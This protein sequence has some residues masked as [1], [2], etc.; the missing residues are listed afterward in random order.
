MVDVTIIG[1]INVDMITS[2]IKKYPDKDSQITIPSIHL[3][4]GGCACNVA[5]SCS[6]MGIKTRLI[7]RLTD[8]V[9]SKYLINHLK[10]IGVNRK[11]KIV[12][13]QTTGVTF[14]ITFT[15]FSVSQIGVPLGVWILIITISSS[16]LCISSKPSQGSTTM[17]ANMKTSI[18]VPIKRPLCLSTRARALR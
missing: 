5:I 10:N 12:K 1:D 16:L 4:P 13:N 9:F 14:S 8:D 7:G 17:T 6:K 18:K 2:P 11:I 15:R 3:D